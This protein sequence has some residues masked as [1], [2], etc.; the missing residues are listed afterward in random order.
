MYAWLHLLEIL[1]IL[2][3]GNTCCVVGMN[4]RL[5]FLQ[6]YLMALNSRMFTSKSIYKLQLDG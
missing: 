2:Y 6:V 1:N 5:Y 4:L 3:Y